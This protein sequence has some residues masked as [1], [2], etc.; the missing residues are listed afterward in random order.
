MKPPEADRL[1]EVT[2]FHCR[3]LNWNNLPLENNMALPSTLFLLLLSTTLV[4]GQSRQQDRTTKRPGKGEPMEGKRTLTG[5]RDR[6]Q[7]SFGSQGNPEKMLKI[8][9]FSADSDHERDSNG[10]CTSATLEA[11]PLPESFTVCTAFMVEVW[12]T[13]F[14][15]AD[16]LI[17]LDNDG[18]PWGT[19]NL[20][21]GPSFTEYEAS[22]GPVY[23][24]NQTET[25]FFPHKWSLAC[26][27]LDL[28][29]SKVM[30]V[31][32]GQLLG[33]MEYKKS[34]DEY[35]PKNI[36]LMLG[37]EPTTQK[38]NTGKHVLNIFNSP[39]SVERMVSQ[40]TVGGKECGAP[41]DL[42]NWEEAEWTLHIFFV[43][44]CLKSW[45]S[46]SIL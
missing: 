20:W 34:E 29:A 8:L 19:I 31:A 33:K 42:V 3:I 25:L 36:S 14:S 7:R 11:G 16:M 39:L 35:R 28:V 13:R 43:F 27:S 40:T 38:E 10:E 1:N 44:F 21:T 4:S 22:L 26:L 6:Q 2:A 23:I 17:L 24:S 30:L 15:S 12:T 45:C 5:N 41:G 18:Y 46:V 9:D 37:F 32:D